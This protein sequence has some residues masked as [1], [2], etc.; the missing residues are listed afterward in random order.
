MRVGGRD[1][2]QSGDTVKDGDD[3]G[4]RVHIGRGRLND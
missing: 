3:D 2:S 4:Y 1:D